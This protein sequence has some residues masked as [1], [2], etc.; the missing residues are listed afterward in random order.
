[1]KTIGSGI[2]VQKEASKTVFLNNINHLSANNIESWA[3]FPISLLEAEN[4]VAFP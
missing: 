3:I 2:P 4:K 1:M